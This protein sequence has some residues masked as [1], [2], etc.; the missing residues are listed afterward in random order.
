[1]RAQ[2]TPGPMATLWPDAG[3]GTSTYWRRR[4]AEGNASPSAVT[5]G[6]PEVLAGSETVI[7]RIMRPLGRKR[8][9]HYATLPAHCPARCFHVAAPIGGAGR[10]SGREGKSAGQAC[11]GG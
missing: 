9:F 2:R 10:A 7:L 1:M 4:G 11:D 6:A 5:V 3:A 8:K